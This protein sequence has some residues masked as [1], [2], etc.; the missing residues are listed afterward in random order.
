MNNTGMNPGVSKRFSLTP[1]CLRA[2]ITSTRHLLI[3]TRKR[4]KSPVSYQPIIHDMVHHSLLYDCREEKN[5]GVSHYHLT[6]DDY[7]TPAPGSHFMELFRYKT[8]LVRY[9]D[10]GTRTTIKSNACFIQVWKYYHN[11]KRIQLVIW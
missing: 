11:S 3:R 10:A 4:G 7:Q 2:N 8:V 9:S 6:T 1:A 5:E